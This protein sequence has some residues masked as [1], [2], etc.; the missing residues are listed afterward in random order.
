MIT[1]CF[2]IHYL[3]HCFY[4][5]LPISQSC[6]HLPFYLDGYFPTSQKLIICSKTQ[7]WVNGRV[8]IIIQVFW[9]HVPSFP[10][11][12][13]IQ[14][15][16]WREGL[17]YKIQWLKQDTSCEFYLC[18]H[19]RAVLNAA[20]ENRATVFQ[21]SSKKDSVLGPWSSWTMF[22]ILLRDKRAFLSDQ[23]KEIEEN[24]RTG[25]TRDLLIKNY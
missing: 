19:P 24:N 13:S 10:T 4:L 25:K 11:S 8:R 2:Y 9:H 21:R 6:Y 3:I 22:M 1:K 12:W 20:V 17:L 18:T 16:W 15:K 7:G 14:Y 5:L 23:C